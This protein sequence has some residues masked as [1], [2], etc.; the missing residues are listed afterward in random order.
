MVLQGW[1]PLWFLLPA[2]IK[3]EIVSTFLI[4]FSFLKM[5]DIL[6]VFLVQNPCSEQPPSALTPDRLLEA[7][8]L[9]YKA[10][11][12]CVWPL[13]TPLT[14]SK[15]ITKMNVLLYLYLCADDWTGETPSRVFHLGD[16]LH[17]EA[18][19]TAP[20]SSQRRLYMDSCVATLEPD[21][22]SVPRYYFIQNHGWVAKLSSA[23]LRV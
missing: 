23:R 19:Y 15:K 2:T 17:L 9:L 10:D 1:P 22:T 14:F 16:L 3:G 11:D 8:G 12:W 5:A 4:V 18:S 13:L 21:P 20:D 6:F 7:L